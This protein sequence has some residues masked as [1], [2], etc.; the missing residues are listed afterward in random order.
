MFHRFEL[1]YFQYNLCA[2][3]SLLPL[4]S[5]FSLID[6]L[7]VLLKFS[8]CWIKNIFVKMFEILKRRKKIT[9]SPETNPEDPTQKKE[10]VNSSPQTSNSV[11]KECNKNQT[12]PIFFSTNKLNE[13]IGHIQLARKLSN[14]TEGV[15]NS[16]YIKQME[17]HYSKYFFSISI[18]KIKL[19]KDAFILKKV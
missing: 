19:K 15:L 1:I 18:L 12:K 11:L 10:N 8:A 2:D 4:P 3:Y 14:Y 17:I 5:P 16:Q 9:T 6:V 7:L 13:A